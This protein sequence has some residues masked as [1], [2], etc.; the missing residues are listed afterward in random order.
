M[1]WRGR[2]K[3]ESQ[4]AILHR[5]IFRNSQ[6]RIFDISVRRLDHGVMLAIVNWE[7][8]GH[9]TLPGARF[10]DVRRGVITSVFTEQGA[11]WRI[12]ALQNTEIVPVEFP[13]GDHT[14]EV[15]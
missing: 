1:H 13:S 8:S 4:H 12:A 7:M 15:R 3:I 11:R 10:A 5:T 9:E 6:L 14:T 2:A